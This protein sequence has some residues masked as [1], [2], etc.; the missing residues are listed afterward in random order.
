MGRKPIL[1]DRKNKNKKVEKWALA[2]LPKL[3]HEDLGELTMDDL[4]LLLKKSKSTIYQYFTTK[5]EFFEYITQ[6]RINQLYSYKNEITEG[7]LDFDYRCETLGRILIEGSKDVSSFFL[8]QLR[9]HYPSSWELIDAFFSDLLEDL[10][11][12]YDLGITNKIFKPVSS[13]FLIKLDRYFIMQLIM[14]KNFFNQPEE[15]LQSAVR[16]YMFLKFEGIKNKTL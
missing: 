3:K 12:L 14:D 5:E 15:T 7:I 10:Q 13:E 8:R 6:V 1:K 9:K 11:Q 16:D 2:I 4:A